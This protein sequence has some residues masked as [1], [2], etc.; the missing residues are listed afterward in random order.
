VPVCSVD[1]EHVD[2]PSREVANAHIASLFE[3]SSRSRL[4]SD[5]PDADAASETTALRTDVQMRGLFGSVLVF[6]GV[7][8]VSRAFFE[9]YLGA[10]A[11]VSIDRFAAAVETYQRDAIRLFTT[12]GEAW[13]VLNDAGDDIDE[14]LRPLEPRSLE[15]YRARRPWR[16]HTPIPDGRLP[17]LGYIS[18][19]TVR[20]ES[21]ERRALSGFLEDL[22]ERIRSDGRRAVEATPVRVRRKMDSLRRKFGSEISHGFFS[23]LFAPDPDELE[24]EAARLAPKSD[25][26]IAQ[27]QATQ[28]AGLRNLADYLSADHMDVYVATSM[29]HRADF[30]SVNH[31]VRALFDHP[32]IAPLKLRYFNPT[33]SWIDDR[34]AKG[35]VEAL[36]LRRAAV[37]IYMAQKQDTFGKDSEASV[38]LGQG[39]PVI[40]YV[41]KL[42]LPASDGVAALDAEA[43]FQSSRRELAARLPRED[44]EHLTR[45]SSDASSPARCA[46]CPRARSSTPC[47]ASGPTSTSTSRRTASR[48]RTSGRATAPGSTASEKRTAR[49]RREPNDRIARLTESRRVVPFHMGCDAISRGSSSPPQRISRSGR[50]CSARF[51][52]SRCR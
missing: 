34:I 42:S 16:L 6:Y 27:M 30:I 33:Q 22:A 20:R 19:A 3:S 32:D 7:G 41:P 44:A 45:R 25:A 13:R 18:A 1:L 9:R 15:P 47:A 17:D 40:V 12:L 29:R 26:E 39:K 5:S 23:P 31:F 4:A 36:M 38:A 43:L 52:R 51:T 28:E 11:F 48:I 46:S 35:L 8:N 14:I 49:T 50:G 10:S 21:A 37:T 24:R 2:A